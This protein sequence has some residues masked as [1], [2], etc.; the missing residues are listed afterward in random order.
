MNFNS[1]SGL[2]LYSLKVDKVT[3]TFIWFN[4][5]LTKTTV[6][7]QSKNHEISFYIALI[8]R[9]V[10]I[11]LP[12]RLILISLHYTLL[13]N[14]MHYK[15]V[16]IALHVTLKRVPLQNSTYYKDSNLLQISKYK[17]FVVVFFMTIHLYLFFQKT[18]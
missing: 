2:W 15:I 18:I 10:I 1:K 4:A 9:T 11:T 12:R 5:G 16:L 14:V 6:I 17:T 3:V 7:P 8:L 13:W